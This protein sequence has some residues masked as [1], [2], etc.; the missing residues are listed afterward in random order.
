[1][2]YGVSQ[3]KALARMEVI[4]GLDSVSYAGVVLAIGNFDGV[5]RGHQAIL[6]AG[7]RRADASGTKL[8]AMTFE[9]HPSA[10]LTPDRV[11]GMLTPPEEKL[12]C[13]EA[14]GA[15]V[16]ILV[17]PQ[18]EFAGVSFLH[19]PAEAFIAEIILK[20]FRPIAM[21]E[22]ASFGFGHHRRGDVEM[23]Q[24]AGQV[25]GFE[26]EVVEPVRVPLGGHPGTVIS[27]SLIRHLLKSGTVDQAAWCLGRPYALLGP[28]VRGAGRGRSLDFPTVNLAIESQLLPVEGVYAGQTEIDGQ[29]LPAA[30]S[31]GRCPTFGGDDITVEAHLLD[32]SG[33]LYGQSIR[34]E[35]L[36]WI[37][38]QRSFDSPQA[39]CEEM[40]RDAL[41]TREVFAAHPSSS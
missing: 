22:G 6:A 41:R 25:H 29:S 4:H 26:V 11:P 31:I 9:P 38:E 3:V 19:V 35:F 8:V 2:R 18:S 15:D 16:V 21:A 12:R 32:F 23:L 27:S 34:L 40:A 5:H 1:L 37:R 17:D 30:I 20:Q 33:H 10:I 24:A 14:A 7:R 13:L 39:L 36:D 28:V